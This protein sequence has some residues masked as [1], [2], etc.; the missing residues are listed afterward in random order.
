MTRD[1]EMIAALWNMLAIARC[2]DFADHPTFAADFNHAELVLDAAG[3]PIER[4]DFRRQGSMPVY[5]GDE[6]VSPADL[7][8]KEAA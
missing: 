2:A 8:A 4:N 6:R 7:L 3:E 1:N 5:V